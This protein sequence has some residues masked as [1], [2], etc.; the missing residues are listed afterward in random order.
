MKGML[1]YLPVALLA[2]LWLLSMVYLSRS[3]RK[4][5]EFME[6]RLA[7]LEDS[8]EKTKITLGEQSSRNT[9]EI[10]HHVRQ[11]KDDIK[12]ALQSAFESVMKRVAENESAQKGRLDSLN[13]QVSVL[14]RK[15]QEEAAK[16]AVKAQ[17]VPVQAATP[18][19]AAPE[20]PAAAAATA[21]AAS[22]GARPAAKPPEDSNSKARRL[23]RLIVSD[24]A[25]Y[26]RKNVEQGVRDGNF[27]E[28]LDHEVREARLLY[29]RRIPEEI[30]KS[31]AY[32]D[33]AFAELILKTRKDLNL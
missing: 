30:R 32:L 17:A 24:I 13:A 14:Q 11:L 3:S 6:E 7:M 33:E 23:A 15:L 12:A 4:K 1:P 10:N 26:N 21:T 19:S 20:A 28:L 5:L 27:Y 9:E 31:T 25:L 18:A 8:L 22:A 2:V 29:E 16:Q